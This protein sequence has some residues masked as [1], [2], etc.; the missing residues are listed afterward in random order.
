MLKNG[1]KYRTW[2]NSDDQQAVLIDKLTK[3]V[4]EIKANYE[5]LIEERVVYRATL[6]IPSTSLE[7]VYDEDDNSWYFGPQPTEE[8]SDFE[9]N[10]TI[11]VHSYD[12]SYIRPLSAQDMIS[13][14]YEEDT[15]LSY[16][17]I[18]IFLGAK[19]PT[20]SAAV[21]RVTGATKIT[22][23]ENLDTKDRENYDAGKIRCDNW[24]G[25]T[26]DCSNSVIYPIIIDDFE[27]RHGLTSFYTGPIVS[28]SAQESNCGVSD[29]PD[30][31]IM[32]Y[33]RLDDYLGQDQDYSGTT[34][35]VLEPITLTISILSRLEA[36][37]GNPF[38]GT[39]FTSVDIRGNNGEE[40]V[41]IEKMNTVY[42]EASETGEDYSALELNGSEGS[43]YAQLNSQDS[44]G[45]R[46]NLY[47]YPIK[48]T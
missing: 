32:M 34:L 15:Y 33:F 19:L 40:D 35:E 17:G 12:P 30:G 18:P 3:D 39:L 7:A 48:L 29:I 5:A 20:D 38:G 9:K 1:R 4:S 46:G 27:F 6:N 8:E 45:N 14:N 36:T 21:V 16:L 43:I 37:P 22:Y 42:L 44:S 11:T 47:V 13:L 31:W 24:D 41:N 28:F 2:Q 10:A 25:W 26:S 23:G